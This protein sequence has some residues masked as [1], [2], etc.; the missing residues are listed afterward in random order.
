[1]LEVVELVDDAPGLGG[2]EF[3]RVAAAG[4]RQTVDARQVAGVRE[5]P[6]QA[7]RGVEAL[8]ELIDE[9]SHAATSIPESTS[10]ARACWNAGR[11]AGSIAHA[12]SAASTSGC[13]ASDRTT[14]T[15]SG[16]FRNTSRRF[17]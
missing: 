8:L 11:R 16:C 12:S 3:A 7:D 13:S 4:R 15:T 5:L 6:R 10:P 1:H 17:P 14:R 2:G 9:A